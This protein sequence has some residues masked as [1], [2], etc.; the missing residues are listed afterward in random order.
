[1]IGEGKIGRKRWREYFYEML[2][3]SLEAEE[4]KEQVLK[5]DEESL[6]D[7]PRKELEEI[8]KN[9]EKQQTSVAN[10]V[11][12]E[13]IKICWRGSNAHILYA[14]KNMPRNGKM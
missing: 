8:I 12:A 1:M 6:V 9:L 13:N 11:T 10:S 5:G 3:E 2:N 4:E 14:Y 7:G